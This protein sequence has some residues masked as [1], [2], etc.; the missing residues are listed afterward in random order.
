M[1]RERTAPRPAVLCALVASLAVIG[2]VGC[3]GQTVASERQSTQ[4]HLMRTRAS[5]DKPH[6]PTYP[7][8]AYTGNTLMSKLVVGDC[9]DDLD[10]ANFEIVYGLDRVPCS[11]SHDSEIYAEP[12]LTGGVKWPG[13]ALIDSESN[14][15]CQAAVD[16]YLGAP[17][18]ATSLQYSYYP[19][20]K[21]A[22]QFLANRHALCVIFQV[23]HQSLGSVEGAALLG[24]VSDW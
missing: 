19:P 14:T 8:S 22:W 3:A 11:E 15:Q 10:S 20:R 18:E 13:T 17:I 9:L 23:G 16:S 12:A 2:L 4:E 6:T 1:S 21:E 5:I 7:Y 24:Y